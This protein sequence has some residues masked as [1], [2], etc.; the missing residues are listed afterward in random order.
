MLNL[1]LSL[2]LW[3]VIILQGI[4][5]LTLIERHFLGLT[6]NRLAPNKVI[7]WGLIQPL[8]DGVKLLKKELLIISHS[9]WLLFLFIP[10]IRFRLLIYEWVVLPYVFQIISFSYR[11]LFFLVVIG[12]SVYPFVLAG[13]VSKSKYGII[14]SLRA[15]RQTISFEVLF[16]LLIISLI[17]LLS[18]LKFTPVFNLLLLHLVILMLISVLVELNR[19]P[20]DFSE[21]E[22]ELVRGYNVEFR[23]VGFV[24]FFLKEYGRILF[25]SCFTSIIFFDFS[26]FI[27]LILIS[28]ILLIRRSYPRFRY[29]L[30]IKLFWFIL[31]PAVINLL[32]VL[33]II[34]C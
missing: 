27:V 31:L 18:S 13:I 5:F 29:D 11:L 14:G 25:F 8:L 1:L 2:L 17:F 16:S 12:C 26:L 23:R 10:S 24:L 15:R 19:A 34:F 33:V 9:N 32:M 4:A 22:S 3:I 20:F 30:I 21:G 28:L 7:L 6:Q